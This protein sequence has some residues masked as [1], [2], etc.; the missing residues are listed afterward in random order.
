M[1]R[2]AIES[3]VLDIEAAKTY[4]L[5]RN[6]EG[7]LNIEQLGVLGTGFGATLALI[8]AVGDWSVATC[9]PTRWGRMS[10]P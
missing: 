2:W 5:Q 6:N 3:M 10:R 1:N 4:L 8:W 9:R 7:K